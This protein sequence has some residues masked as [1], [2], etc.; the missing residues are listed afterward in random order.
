M[1]YGEGL[2]LTLRQKISSSNDWILSSADWFY[3][4]LLLLHKHV[5]SEQ[6]RDLATLSEHF[7]SYERR[8]LRSLCGS[9]VS[10]ASPSSTSLAASPP[11]RELQVLTLSGA[12]QS[13]VRDLLLG[14][15]QI[16][17]W[18]KQQRAALS[19]SACHVILFIC[20]QLCGPQKGYLAH[21]VVMKHIKIL[22]PAMLST[23]SSTWHMPLLYSHANCH[24]VTRTS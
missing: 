16:T 21:N 6:W 19:F 23:G 4:I 10:I 9:F 17:G 14:Y 22:K 7:S 15:H 24:A 12:G 2:M 13:Q 8:R 11:M 20:R 5:Y 18:S 3:S 1:L